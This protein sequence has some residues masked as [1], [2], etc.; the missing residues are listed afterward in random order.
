MIPSDDV[1]NETIEA[2]FQSIARHTPADIHTQ[3]IIKSNLKIVYIQAFLKGQA[4]AV[5]DIINKYQTP[6]EREAIRDSKSI[7]NT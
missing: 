7:P 1:I 3:E 6:S 5:Q 4:E 2:Q